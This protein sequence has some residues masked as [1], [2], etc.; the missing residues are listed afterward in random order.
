[1][2]FKLVDPQVLV[3]SEILASV[4]VVVQ[5]Y[6][7]TENQPCLETPENIICLTSSGHALPC[8]SAMEINL[9]LRTQ[10]R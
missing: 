8:T 5:L 7:T 3:H 4:M 6:R 9:N 10:L 2:Y 1:M